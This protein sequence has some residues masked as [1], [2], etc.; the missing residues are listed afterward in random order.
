MTCTFSFVE[1]TVSDLASSLAWYRDVPGLN[2]LMEDRSWALLGDGAARIALKAGVPT[3]GTILLT[4][5][6]TD[7]D[8]WVTRL[9]QRGI[10]LDEPIKTSAE[11][12][13]RALVRDP[14]GYRLSFFEWMTRDE[15]S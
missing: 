4:F 2:V 14:D 9:Q 5:E 10:A 15:P 12:Y 11:G 7:L 6:L 13:R 3:P 1:L 8:G